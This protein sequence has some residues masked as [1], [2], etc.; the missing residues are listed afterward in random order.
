MNDEE[1]CTFLKVFLE[2]IWWEKKFSI[3]L[4]SLY[5]TSR[6]ASW[7]KR[8]KKEFFEKIYINREVVQEASVWFYIKWMGKRN[9]PINSLFLFFEALPQNLS[10]SEKVLFKLKF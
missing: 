1:K 10:S 7:L 2:N 8:L 4:H 6:L 5:K 3:P 9:E